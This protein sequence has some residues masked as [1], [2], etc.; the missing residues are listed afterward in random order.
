VI[1]PEVFFLQDK[2]IYSNLKPGFP[3]R[4]MS[5]SVI[6][7]EEKSEGTVKA[8]VDTKAEYQSTVLQNQ[9]SQNYY[10]QSINTASP[11][12]LVELLYSGALNF[13]EQAKNAIEEKDYITANT[14]IVRV[15]D[16]I[17]ELNISLDIEKGQSIATN[18]RELYTFL[19]RRL[20][21]A[22]SKKDLS[23][24]DEVYRFIKEL[25]D[26][27]LEVMK[28]EPHR[29]QENRTDKKVLDISR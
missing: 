8:A 21:E 20:L 3:K 5:E 14:K 24:L 4:V 25:R 6:T 17:M 22:N 2:V 16:I 11:A 23:I 28:K 10:E 29:P 9:Y 15:E 13:I 18:L 19:Y 7:E 1:I 12:K 26:I 27:W